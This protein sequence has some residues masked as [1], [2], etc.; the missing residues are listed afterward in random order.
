MEH[1]LV[2][3]LPNDLQ[4]IEEAV[5]FVVHRCSTCDQVARKLRFNFRVCLTEALAN[6]MIYGNRRDPSKRVRVEVFVHGNRL[7]ARVTDQGDG[8]NPDRLPDPTAP[9]NLRK[10]GG[11]GIF[12]MRKLMDEV[13]FNERGNAVTLVLLLPGPEPAVREATA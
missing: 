13:H 5:E 8:F 9:A 11:R 1:E 4:F 12:L 10:E 6:A 7:R 2:F 3:E